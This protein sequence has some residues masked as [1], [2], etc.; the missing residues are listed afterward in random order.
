MTSRISGD[1]EARLTLTPDTSG[2]QGQQFLLC[3]V[4][5]AHANVEMQLLRIGRVPSWLKLMRSG[6]EV[7]AIDGISMVRVLT[8]PGRTS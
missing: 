1:P 6:M 8:R 5:V 7:D 2:A 3:L 4:C